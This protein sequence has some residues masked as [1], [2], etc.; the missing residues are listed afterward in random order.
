[1]S[2]LI[3]LE[4]NLVEYKL[5]FIN[6]QSNLKNTHNVRYKNMKKIVFSII[7]LNFSSTS[8]NISRLSNNNNKEKSSSKSSTPSKFV[9]YFS[10]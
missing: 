7:N 5:Y 1:M 2:I 10:K 8:T 4:E 6:I 9:L 3:K